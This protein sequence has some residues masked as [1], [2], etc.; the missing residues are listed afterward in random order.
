MTKAQQQAFEAAKLA[1]K[2]VK[3]AEFEIDWSDD[4]NWTPVQK[5]DLF[6]DQTGFIDGFA[7][8]RNKRKAWLAHCPGVIAM[9]RNT[10]PDTGSTDF[11]IVIGQAPRYLDRNLTVFGRV[12]LGM[13]VVQG[14]RRG[15]TEN[16]GIIEKDEDRT[17]I[18][19]MQMGADLP[20]ADQ[21]SIYVM[22]TS[23][24]GFNAYMESRRNRKDAFFHQKPPAVLDVCQVPV[25]SRVEK[26]ASPNRR[27]E[28]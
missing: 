23:G 2:R 24:E 14:I 10:A 21:L 6:A 28:P 1:G 12:V 3:L 25:A 20:E 17:R 4:L 15:P 27:S 16:N 7:A 8:A 13:D 5:R 19:R 11:Y 26:P 22:D 18:S 9:A